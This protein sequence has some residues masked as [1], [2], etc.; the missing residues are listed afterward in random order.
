MTGED[1]PLNAVALGPL[2]QKAALGATALSRLEPVGLSE[3]SFDDDVPRLQLSVQGTFAWWRLV[4]RLHGATPYRTS[5]KKQHLDVCVEDV[6]DVARS[7]SATEQ[8]GSLLF[9]LG[10]EKLPCDLK[11]SRQN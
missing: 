6:R 11:A 4:A 8:F 10:F 3:T 7:S 1:R 5:N 2:P 9:R